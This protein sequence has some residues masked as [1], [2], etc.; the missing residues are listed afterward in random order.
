MGSGERPAGEKSERRLAGETRQPLD[1]RTK[2]EKTKEGLQGV[3][4]MSRKVE[5][6]EEYPVMHNSATRGVLEY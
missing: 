6:P 2:Q 5:R 3:Q 1:R 4:K